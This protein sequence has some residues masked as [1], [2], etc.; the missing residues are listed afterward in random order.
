MQVHT[1]IIHLILL[2]F[3]FLESVAN[4]FPRILAENHKPRTY[5]RTGKSSAEA[6]VPAGQD[7]QVAFREGVFGSGYGTV[8]K[9][10]FFVQ[11]F[12]FL[13]SYGHALYGIW[14]ETNKF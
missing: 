7:R 11:L 10:K 4:E 14:T 8:T 13:G 12:S 5:C 6:S 1:H 3:E 2:L 9:N